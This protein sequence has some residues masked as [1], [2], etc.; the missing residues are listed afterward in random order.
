MTTDF[1]AV[2]TE[3]SKAVHGISDN[4]RAEELQGGWNRARI[5]DETSAMQGFVARAVD[6]KQLIP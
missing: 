4:G 1:H 5:P 6:S 3:G 2:A